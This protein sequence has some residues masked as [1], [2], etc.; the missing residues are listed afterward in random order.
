MLSPFYPTDSKHTPNANEVIKNEA[1]PKGQLL[2]FWGDEE[3]FR[4]I[5]TGN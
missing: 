4:R 1:D 2:F 5:T 3:K